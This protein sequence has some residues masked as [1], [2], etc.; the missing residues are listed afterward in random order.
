MN[1]L[2][3]NLPEY[4]KIPS[5]KRPLN[6]SEPFF[7]GKD[8]IVGYPIV[9]QK[10]IDIKQLRACLSKEMFSL[11]SPYL[12]FNLIY[13]SNGITDEAIKLLDD[14]PPY[15][16]ELALA[17]KYEIYVVNEKLPEAANYIKEIEEKELMSNV[18]H[19]A[20]PSTFY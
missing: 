9:A 16:H 6:V 13:Y 11:L 4:M 17:F 2:N 14:F 5:L 10:N 8:S 12:M 7:Y 15:L 18:V 1:C 19:E 20:Y 3:T